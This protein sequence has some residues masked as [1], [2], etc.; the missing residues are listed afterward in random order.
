MDI[1]DINLI[2]HKEC[3]EMDSIITSGTISERIAVTNKGYKVDFLYKDPN[4]SVRIQAILH[5]ADPTKMVNDP[6][7]KVRFV[8]V[9]MIEKALSIKKPEIIYTGIGIPY[10]VSSPERNALEQFAYDFAPAVKM[11]A[12][13][14]LTDVKRRE[15]EEAIRVTGANLTSVPTDTQLKKIGMFTS[16]DKNKD[17]NR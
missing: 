8:A 1:F 9:E 15:L 12:F 4:P 5:G 2:S 3:K 17:I 7:Q 10:I 14:I 16:E 11:K 13:Q 6:V